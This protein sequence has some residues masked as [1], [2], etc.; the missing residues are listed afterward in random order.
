MPAK[1][2]TH[3]TPKLGA[4]AHAERAVDPCLRRGDGLWVVRGG[5]TRRAKRC[6]TTSVMPAKAGT[7]DT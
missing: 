3:D 7:H 2:G 1:A 6:S 4:E 5:E